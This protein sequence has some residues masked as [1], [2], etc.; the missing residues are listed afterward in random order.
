[1]KTSCRATNL[2]PLLQ[3]MAVKTSLEEFIRVY[4]ELSGEDERG[5]RLDSVLRST[6]QYTVPAHRSG[7]KEITLDEDVYA[8]LLK[9]LNG[10]TQREYTNS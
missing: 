4:N 7:G 10:S 5:M 8:A 3:D 9:T 2:H 1:M 6:A